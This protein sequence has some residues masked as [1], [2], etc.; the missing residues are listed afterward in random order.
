MNE[1]KTHDNCKYLLQVIKAI[2]NKKFNKI[3]NIIYGANEIINIADKDKKPEYN[4]LKQIG[5]II[6]NLLIQ[7]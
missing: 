4:S 7:Y 1:P 6:K 3:I 2:A 5:N